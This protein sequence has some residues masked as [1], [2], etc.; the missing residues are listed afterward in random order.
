MIKKV[1]FALLLIFSSLTLVSCGFHKKKQSSLKPSVLVSIPPYCTVVEKIAG[2][3]VEVHSAVAP[4]F[5]SHTNE[6]TPGQA[7]MIQTCN[8][9]IG[10]GEAYEKKLLTSLKES[11]LNVQILEL[12]KVTPLLPLS[13][14]DHFDTCGAAHEHD[15]SAQDLHFWMSP[16]TLS[17]QATKIAEALSSLIPENKEFYAYNLELYEAE[18]ERINQHIIEQLLPY[19]GGG[20]IVSHPFLGYFCHDY[21][22]VQISVECE[23][24]TAQAQAVNRILSLADTYQIYAVFTSPQYNNKGARLI[25]NELKLQTDE[26]DPLAVDPLS[27]IQRVA[28]DI[29]KSK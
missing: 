27:T 17:F 13:E 2:N 25:A 9:W 18:I 23:G 22:L 3:T 12:N 15:H 29:V 20:V 28:D 4:G 8:L 5:D 6:I 7:Q 24:K 19:R 1:L 14:D 11:N 10:I 16:Q 21:Q 26:V